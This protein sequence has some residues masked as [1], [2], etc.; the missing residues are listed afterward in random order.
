MHTRVHLHW[1][2]VHVPLRRDSDQHPSPLLLKEESLLPLLTFH[3]SFLGRVY[4]SAVSKP[5]QELLI[6]N[7]NDLRPK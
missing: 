6:N 1:A 2:P 3:V 7:R 5:G 4:L